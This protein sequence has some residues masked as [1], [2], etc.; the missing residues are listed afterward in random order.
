M[1]I[2]DQVPPGVPVMK[3]KRSEIAYSFEMLSAGSRVRIK[4]RNPRALEA[5]HSVLRL[6]IQDHYTGDSGDVRQPVEGISFR[7]LFDSAIAIKKLLSGSEGSLMGLFRA[8]QEP[9][10]HS[11]LIME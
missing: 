7:K 2:H 6:Q 4:T 11:E 9:E 10:M 3:E 5:V 1:F 8:A